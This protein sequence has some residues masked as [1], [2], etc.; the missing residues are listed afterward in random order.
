MAVAAYEYT[1]DGG[2]L[3]QV[4]LPTDFA[5]SSNW[6][7]AVGTEPYL[8]Q[9]ISPRYATYV[10][11]SPALWVSVVQ[12]RKTSSSAIAQ[13]IL[14]QGNLYKFQSFIGEVRNTLLSGNII[15][16]SGPQGPTGLQ[17][18]QGTTGST[19]PT[20]PAGP[21][22]VV[23]FVTISLAADVAI[24]TSTY[25][26]L[27]AYA[28]GFTGL[29]RLACEIGFSGSA[30]AFQF[31][32]RVSLAG[33]PIGLPCWNTGFV[34]FTNVS[35]EIGFNNILITD[36]IIVEAKAITNAFTVKKLDQTGGSLGTRF[37]VWRY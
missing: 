31:L 24:N 14:V 36:G 21:T 18:P 35:Y 33:T 26:S 10:C 17:G 16:I 34:N 30:G 4:V 25:S 19:G 32:L 5:A 27:L 28:P 1:D 15:T 7:P 6:L 22:G 37:T 2:S 13:N 12:T 11:P 3:W 8:P 9:W 29:G 20:G 23:S